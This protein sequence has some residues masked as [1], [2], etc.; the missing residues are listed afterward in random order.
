MEEH[1]HE[2]IFNVHKHSKQLPSNSAIGEWAEALLNL[3][4]TQRPKRHPLIQL[5]VIPDFTSFSNNQASTMIN[6]K[7]FSNRCI[8]MNIDPCF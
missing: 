8:G 2:H 5:N 6:V 1:F 3:L 7:V 4:F